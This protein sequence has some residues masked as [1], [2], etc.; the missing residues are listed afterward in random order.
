MLCEQCGEHNSAANRFCQG[1]GVPLS[2]TCLTCEHTNP[3]GSAF[4]GACGGALETA[5]RPT[6]PPAVPHV[7]NV[8]RGELKQVTV[9][10]ADLVSST[11]L[12]ARLNAEDAMLRLKP[13][14]NTMCEAVERFEGTV[15]RTLGDGI[16]AFFGAPRAQEGHAL[17]ACEAA[18]AIR[19]APKLRQ[20]S[21]SIRIGLH[22]GEIVADAPLVDSVSERGAYGLTIHQ[23]SSR[24]SA[25]PWRYLNFLSWPRPGN[26]PAAADLGGRRDQ[27]IARD[28]D[29]RS[30]RH[31]QEPSL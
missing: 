15:V 5:S 6:H 27:W 22:S 29:C 9:L 4:C 25:I 24:Q 18:L 21:M 3:S 13:A 11:E 19:D 2:V 8:V 14:L 23:A 28:R 30:P 31:R 20:E 1:C 16:L 10:F 7:I 12:V 17:L 26:Q